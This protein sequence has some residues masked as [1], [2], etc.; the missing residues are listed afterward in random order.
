MSLP[1]TWHI[2]QIIVDVLFSVVSACV[3]NQFHGHW[4][5]SSA[6][7]MSTIT[8]NLKLKE[9]IKISSNLEDLIDDDYVL[10]LELSFLLLTLR[11][12]YVGF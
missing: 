2:S 9:K 7:N 4:L 12:K 1:L 10:V 6:L 3:S 11:E 5:F 8:M